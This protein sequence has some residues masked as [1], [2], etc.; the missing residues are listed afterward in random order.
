MKR[1]S[2]NPQDPQALKQ[3]Y[4]AQKEMSNWAESKNKPGQFTGHTGAKILSKTE[5]SM[6]IQAWALQEQFTKAQKVQGEFEFSAPS[7][8]YESTGKELHFSA[9]PTKVSRLGKSTCA[10]KDTFS[11]C[12]QNA[13]LHGM[14]AG[15]LKTALTCTFA[16]AHSRAR[17]I[18]TS[19]G[20]KL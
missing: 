16:K 17:S 18:A 19:H 13:F 11:Q 5:L 7:N 4:D 8:M 1:L 20:N 9:L 2:E 14:S 12:S 15:A 10:F 6:G 3:L